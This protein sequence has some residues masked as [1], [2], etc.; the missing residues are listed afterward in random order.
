MDKVQKYASTNA[1]TP[2]SETYRS[3]LWEF[4]LHHDVQT[5]SGTHPASYPMGM[6]GCYPVGKVAIA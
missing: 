2:L 4:S 3:D 6:R 5:G 1:N